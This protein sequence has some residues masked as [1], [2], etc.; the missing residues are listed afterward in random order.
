[1]GDQE[2]LIVGM[3]VE[4]RPDKSWSNG[5]EARWKGPITESGPMANT[6]FTS[7]FSPTSTKPAT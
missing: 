6:T 7:W 2:Q 3:Q 1:V 4:N 5:T